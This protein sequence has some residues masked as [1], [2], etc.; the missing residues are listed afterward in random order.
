NAPKEWNNYRDPD[1]TTYNPPIV[2][3]PC[4]DTAIAIN[5]QLNLT[6]SSNDTGVTIYCWQI[7]TNKVDT[8]SAADT[9]R[10]KLTEVSDT[11]TYKIFVKAICSDGIESPLDSIIVRVALCFPVIQKIP[12]T[13][14]SCSATVLINFAATDSAGTIVKYLIDINNSG[15][16]CTTQTASYT[17]SGNNNGPQTIIWAAVNNFGFLTTDTFTIFFNLKPDSASLVSPSSDMPAKFISFDYGNIWGKLAFVITGSDPDKDT[18]G[19]TYSFYLGEYDSQLKL[20]HSGKDTLFSKDSLLPNTKYSWLLCAKDSFND[21]IV[22]T[23]DFTT[24][25][26]PENPPGMKLIRSAGKKF[27]MSQENDTGSHSS[28]H[29]VAFTNNFWMDSTEITNEFFESITG[30]EVDKS[31]GSNYPVSNVTW[32]DAILFC[33]SRS[34]KDGLDT[35]YSYTVTNGI[36][37]N[38]NI[39]M[40]KFGYRLPTEA[41]WEFA[42][43]A[44]SGK[45]FYWGD[46][47]IDLEKYAWVCLTS[48][49]EVHEVGKR[50]PN[51]YGLYDMS[52]NLFEWCNDWYD[53]LSSEMQTDPV[54]SETGVE[55]VLRGG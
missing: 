11:G 40:T 3:L 33:N 50:L 14:A 18:S 9:F 4:K 54:G 17:F 48:E 23:G 25:K 29:E 2:E 45:L 32:F 35:V 5:Q 30:I 6:A 38:V 15:W 31:L 55:R 16:I 28:E 22:T 46:G 53:T 52:G 12:D 44:E 13:T 47:T 7:D 37:D 20:I 51:K 41:E 8:L 43:R 19:L 49:N 10:F 21:S 27:R 1:G 39:D 36:P 26:G 34:K 42:C 24:E